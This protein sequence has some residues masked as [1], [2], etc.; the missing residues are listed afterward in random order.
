MEDPTD[1]E[2]QF[3]GQFKGPE[4][5]GLP[6]F[7]VHRPQSQAISR[8]PEDQGQEDLGR[9]DPGSKGLEQDPAS[10]SPRLVAL[11]A[12]VKGRV[13][14]KPCLV[15]PWPLG[16]LR[17]EGEGVDPDPLRFLRVHHHLSSREVLEEVA[18]Q[19]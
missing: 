9:G 3:M 6:S 15:T 16:C 5:L 8:A 13:S 18:S 11:Q 19:T 2:G 7:R 10:S 14:S 4:H 17:K 12:R 1:L